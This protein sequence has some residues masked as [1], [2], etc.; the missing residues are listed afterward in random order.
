VNEILFNAGVCF[1]KAKSF[2]N[3]ITM[4]EALVQNF[5]TTREAKLSL[6]AL[7]ANYAAI[8]EYA[9]AAAYYEKYAKQFMGEK[10]ASQALQY[11]V[12][13]Y[14]GIGFTS[15]D[16]K[17]GLLDGKNDKGRVKI[18]GDQKAI[19]DTETFVGRFMKG[20]PADAAAAYYSISA[21]YEKNKKYDDEVK[22]LSDYI[23]RFG[24]K[25]G[26]DRLIIAHVK[27]GE[28]VWR[29]SCPVRGVNGACVDM[30]K[31]RKDIRKKKGPRTQCGSP[32]KVKVIAYDRKGAFVKD[33]QTHFQMAIKLWNKGA[34]E[35]DV[36]GKDDSEK[37]GRT[38]DMM[39]WVAAA[40]FYM[41]ET[42]YEKTLR[43]PFPHDLDFDKEKHPGK[44]KDSE[45]RFL[46]WIKDRSDAVNKAKGQYMFIV[47]ELKGGA[48]HWAIASAARVGQMLQAYA[49][50]IFTA[51]IPK[52]VFKYGEDGI[53]AYCDAL[54]DESS[55]GDAAA[56]TAF[57]FCLKTA[58]DRNWSNEWSQLCESELS[59]SDRATQYPPA[60]E[61]RG[62]AYEEPL[63]L[64]TAPINTDL[65]K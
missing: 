32:D 26:V 23:R 52:D 40:H 34:A 21:I 36:P 25:G 22:L 29:Q 42:D 63:N 20:S 47:N 65:A 1:E 61:I 44:A 48:A 56:N 11:A 2:Q 54:G 62:D 17:P 4:R 16:A 41:A 50:A 5:G 28:I 9:T 13:F 35:K 49:G 60:D 57:E 59:Q 55:K 58:T 38:G 6:Y 45:K 31:G 64:A 8:A 19:D 10:D 39:Y 51:E 7:G 37:A 18:D 46:K 15:R 14:K 30:I 27:I 53:D 24:T 33:A 3:A 43:I 12:F